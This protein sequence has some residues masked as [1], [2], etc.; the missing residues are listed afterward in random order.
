MLYKLKYMKFGINVIAG[1]LKSI[2]EIWA[3]R[4]FDG[5]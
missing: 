3:E 1:Q 4:K 5:S 2:E